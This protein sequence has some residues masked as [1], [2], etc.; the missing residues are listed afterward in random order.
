MR[1]ISRH[2][3][4]AYSFLAVLAITFI[5]SNNL[6][7]TPIGHA[8]WVGVNLSGIPCRG[9]SEN[10]GPFDYLQRHTLVAE[11]GIVEKYHF[12]P[13]V[14]QLVGGM[15]TGEAQSVLSD[16]HYTLKAWP[17]HHRAL[18]SVIQYQLI[19]AKGKKNLRFPPAECYLERAIKFSPK[20]ATT[21]MLYAN[22]L[23]RTGHK[24]RALEFYE[25]ALTLKPKGVQIKYNFAL[26]LV[27]LKKFERAKG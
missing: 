15:R 19:Q 2:D 1:S 27:D 13:Q 20:D 17:N 25:K 21:H 9:D 4:S 22:L 18:N 6:H 11:L 3:I 12:G 16:I 8:P 10:F 26:L 23:Q 5:Y 7:A 24:K 14:E